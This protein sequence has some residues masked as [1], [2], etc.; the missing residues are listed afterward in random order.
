MG[1][2][3]PVATE[4]NDGLISKNSFSASVLRKLPNNYIP[5]GKSRL[6]K[7]PRYAVVNL[8]VIADISVFKNYT[9][10]TTSSRSTGI[11]SSYNTSFNVKFYAKDDYF[12]IQVITS[13][14]SVYTYYNGFYYSNS[15]SIIAEEVDESEIIDATPIEI[16]YQ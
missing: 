3:L 15:L 13:S 5:N 14:N 7:I 4:N 2:L 6:W 1:G 16:S 8:L 9:F 11:A 12:L 10:V